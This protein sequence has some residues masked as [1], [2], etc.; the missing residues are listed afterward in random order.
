MDIVK[1]ARS[2]L[3]VRWR[4][5]GRTVEK[6]IDCLGLIVCVVHD[7][8]LYVDEDY[9]RYRKFPTDDTMRRKMMEYFEYVSTGKEQYGDIMMLAGHLKGPPQ[10][11]GF[12][13]P[14]KGV[15]FGLIHSSLTAKV[16]K[17]VEQN[18]SVDYSKLRRGTFRLPGVKVL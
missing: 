3:G 13:S 12:L 10:H 4:H 11:V 16:N 14:G 5:Q 2:Y 6:G 18:I 7:M 15:P 17:V 8:G 1:A 9:T